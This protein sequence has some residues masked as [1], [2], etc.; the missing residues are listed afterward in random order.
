MATGAAWLAAVESVPAA[1]RPI[2]LAWDGVGAL[3]AAAGIALAADVGGLPVVGA[4]ALV[5]LVGAYL[6]AMRRGATVGATSR[7][8]EVK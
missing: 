4:T 3:L 2:V 7:P 1:L 6:A 8:P 5:A